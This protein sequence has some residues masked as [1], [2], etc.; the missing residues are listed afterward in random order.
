VLNSDPARYNGQEVL[1][2]GFIKLSPEG[3]VLYESGQLDAEFA[4]KVDAGGRFDAKLYRKYCLTI[5][6]PGFFYQHQDQLRGRTLIV[7]GKFIENYLDGHSIDL[8]A[9]PLP[10]AVIIDE[11]DFKRR[12]G[13][14]LAE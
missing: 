10:T 9:C 4:R 3:H 11:Q 2:R 12:Y 13:G 7:Q 14:L 8:G 6:N 1:V 5:A